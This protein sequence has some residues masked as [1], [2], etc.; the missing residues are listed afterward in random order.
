MNCCNYAGLVCTIADNG[1]KQ[2]PGRIAVTGERKEDAETTDDQS[3]M[4]LVAQ[5]AGKWGL[6]AAITNDRNFKSTQH[7]QHD[8]V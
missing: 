7:D 4:G 5:S 3:H 6:Q 8:L 2:K 1:I